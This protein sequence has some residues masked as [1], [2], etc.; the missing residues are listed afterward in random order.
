MATPIDLSELKTFADWCHV[1]DRLPVETQW[2]VEALLDL[3]EGSIWLN[4]SDEA[5]RQ[6][7]DEWRSS[8]GP[9]LYA[10]RSDS[11]PSTQDST[12]SNHRHG[13]LLPPPTRNNCNCELADRILSACHFIEI[14]GS[15]HIPAGYLTDLRPMMGLTHLIQLDLNRAAGKLSDLTPLAALTNLLELKLRENRITDISPLAELTDLIELD[16]SSNQITDLTPLTALIEL[17][18]LDLSEN[19]IT[20]L[21][22]LAALKNLTSLRLSRNNLTDAIDFRPLLALTKLTHLSLDRNNITDRT[23]E[24]IAELT[25]LESLDIS[26]NRITDVSVLATLPHL[27]N[28]DIKYNSITDFSAS[29]LFED[30]ATPRLT[31]EQPADLERLATLTNLTKLELIIDY[32]VKDEPWLDLTPLSRL[33]RLTWLNL[34]GCG[35]KDLT[36]L[37]TLTNLTYLRIGG[38]YLANLRPLKFLRNL[39]ELDISSSKS[40][41]DLSP[42][43]ALTKLTKL[44][45]TGDSQIS[46]LS[47]LQGLTELTNLRCWNAK[48]TDISPLASLT[49]LKYLNLVNNQITDISPLR[50]LVNLREL[51]INGNPIKDATPLL[52]LPKL[53]NSSVRNKRITVIGPTSDPAIPLTPLP[54]LQQQYRKVLTQPINRAKATAAIITMYAVL[55]KAVPTVYFSDSPLA[56]VRRYARKQKQRI[57][58][59]VLGQPIVA[60]LVQSAMPV[61]SATWKAAWE[62]M[63]F[64]PGE[65]IRASLGNQ[66]LGDALI[67]S[68][69]WFGSK[70]MVACGSDFDAIKPRA[71]LTPE[72][73]VEIISVS[74]M[75][76]Q[77]EA[78]PMRSSHY[79]AKEAMQQLLA[80]C[81]WIIPYEKACIVCDRPRYVH[82]D[83]ENRLHAMSEPAIEFADGWRSGYYQN[84]QQLSPEVV[85]IIKGW[86]LLEKTDYQA[87]LIYCE[88]SI[89]AYPRQSGGFLTIRGVALMQL[90]VLESAMEAFDR[91]IRLDQNNSLAWYNRACLR[92]KQGQLEEAIADLK[93][94]LELFPELT[95][96]VM[97]DED[98]APIRDRCMVWQ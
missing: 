78:S 89:A 53:N 81:G 38:S 85:A 35:I 90:G 75:Y 6:E 82:L 77:Q 56:G 54:K 73:L 97:N 19:S 3:I 50:S 11:V 9:Q 21:S 57:P 58:D 48:I 71:Y 43:A 49:K 29:N 93:Q 12:V 23:L 27:Y 61:K 41:T 86:R 98:F 18:E 20:D 34:Y 51:Y 28:L 33:T 39:T 30:L 76:A 42:L 60:Q 59:K 62:M 63:Q 80:T 74:Q 1:R 22:P 10:R 88:D 37:Q 45:I 8:R 69:Q 64:Q 44:D 96:A 16:L 67:E 92:A 31:I 15:H 84:G 47:P 46:D 13:E 94:A 91:A 14:R 79:A 65:A 40:L 83:E 17:T 87:T 24:T 72:D 2:T 55:G 36:P 68:S 66:I 70:Q 52:T 4:F 5:L 32:A 26:S 25:T 7:W 95:D